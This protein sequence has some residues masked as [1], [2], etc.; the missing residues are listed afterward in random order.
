VKALAL[1]ALVGVIHVHHAPSH[2]SDAPF[3]AVLS[4]A[5]EAGLDFVVLTDHA[6]SDSPGLLPGSEHAGLATAPNGRKVLILVGAEFA[7]RDGHVL[8]LEIERGVPAIG[9]PG[10]EV[11]AAIHEQG[12]F[13]VVAH[14]F[15]HGGWHD[16]D[17]EFDG[18]E[19]QNNASDFTRLYGPL[20]PFRL[21][22]FGFDRSAQ[23]EDLWVRPSRELEAWDG[24]LVSGRRVVGF[25][26]ADAHNNVSLLGWQLDPYLQMFRGVQTVCPD[27]EL[28]PR[29][30]WARLRSGSCA[31]RYGIHE[32]RAA[33]ATLIELPSGRSELQLD[34]GTRVLELRNPPA[35]PGLYSAP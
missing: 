6:D 14:P 25:A 19:V 9:R 13:A 12:G 35:E 15:S 34:G 16:W 11:I 3:E 21:L 7:S 24:L 10:R 5:G 30:V 29:A 26:G 33:E 22:R 17:A 8:G 31:I 28:E 4:A 27:G 23:L 1:A 2:D 20:L 32:A 18:L